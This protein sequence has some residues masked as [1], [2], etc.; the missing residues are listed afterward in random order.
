M[1]EKNHNYS[2]S[3]FIFKL[4]YR[5]KWYIIG[6]TAAAAIASIIIALTLPVWYKA[7]ISVV[8]PK[9]DDSGLSGA[10]GAV[11]SA[12]K[13]FGLTRL[14]G[15]AMQSY[16]YMVILESRSVLDSIINKYNIAE[17]YEIKDGTSDD[18]RNAFWENLSITLEDGGNYTISIWDKDPEIAAEMANE[19]IDIANEIAVRLDK[20]EAIHNRNSIFNRLMKTDSALKAVGDSLA[21][22]S[23]ESLLY[24][25]EEQAA[26]ISSSLAEIKANL[27]KEEI[28]YEFLKNTYGADDPQA[29][30]QEQL[31]EQAKLKL[32]DIESTP[33]F[34]GNFSLHEVG[35]LGVKY[36]RFYVEYET[37]SQVKAFLLPMAE[38]AEIDINAK[39]RYLYI[40]D[41][42]IAP[43]KKDKPRRSFIVA[44][45]TFGAF[46]VACLVVLLFNAFIDF[47]N[48]IK[49]E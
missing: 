20:T 22:F 43:D 12:L 45:S 5:N 19:Y 29:K 14:G 47:K 16:D 7:T 13:D 37:F 4:L 1:E 48:N 31:V 34:A 41:P 46:V 38:K 44:G 3:A 18:I 27:I 49:E 42:A 24:S 28:S 36:M 40:L 2:D 35:E 39:A 30:M 6:F 32:K 25:P 15:G 23:R 11:G 17:R 26:A 21:K 33:G 10:M 9:S 8:P